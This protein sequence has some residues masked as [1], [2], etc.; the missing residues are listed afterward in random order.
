M[1]SKDDSQGNP[2]QGNTP[3]RNISKDDIM[4]LLETTTELV[5]KLMTKLTGAEENL[6]SV[7]KDLKSAQDDGS[8]TGEKLKEAESRITALTNELT[9]ARKKSTEDMKEILD[10]I[11]NLNRTI[12]QPSTGAAGAEEKTTQGDGSQRKYLKYKSKYINL[13]RRLNLN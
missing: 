1:S 12:Q 8:R 3:Q 5:Q 7:N 10:K 9:E 2:P 13:K 4:R 11:K 6:K